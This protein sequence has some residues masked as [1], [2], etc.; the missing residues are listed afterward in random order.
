MG[1]NEEQFAGY[2]KRK[3]EFGKSH[4]VVPYMGNESEIVA[5]I[6]VTS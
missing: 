5:G 3:D 1:S 6:R 2:S 4:H